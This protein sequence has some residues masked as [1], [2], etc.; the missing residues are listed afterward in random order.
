MESCFNTVG[1]KTLFALI[2]SCIFVALNANGQ[3]GIDYFPKVLN[4]ELSKWVSID[5]NDLTEIAIAGKS[6]I[7]GKYFRINSIRVNPY[8]FVYIGRVNSCR[9]GGCS[10][11]LK[12]MIETPSEYFDYFILFDQ[13]KSVKMVKVFNYQATH[14]HEVSTPAWLKQ[15][16]GY[17]GSTALKVG[18][19]IDAISGATISVNG[20]TS[21]IEDKTKILTQVLQ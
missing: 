13:K 12:E 21:D 7:T 15:F 19:N 11:S 17:N 2:I 8:A 14:G 20:I 16:S 4:K 9:S 3:T 1:M 18:K 10:V 5:K 6:S